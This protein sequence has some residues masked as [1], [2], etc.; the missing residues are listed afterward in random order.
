MIN[1][2]SVADEEFTLVTSR[3]KKNRSKQFQIKSQV[4]DISEVVD[5]KSV[6]K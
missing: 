6:L 5:V 4:A 1:S 2:H 3:R